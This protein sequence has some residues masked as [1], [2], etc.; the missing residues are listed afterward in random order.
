MV[1]LNRNFLDDSSEDTEV[2]KWTIDSGRTSTISIS[3]H[4][5]ETGFKDIPRIRNAWEAM[6]KM[7]EQDW[8]KIEEQV[9]VFGVEKRKFDMEISKC[10]DNGN[11][12][13]YILYWK[14]TFFVPF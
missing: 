10:D 3:S 4:D 11:S 1:I 14:I 5:V 13:L 12:V 6:K 9:N 2:G 8:T 7:R